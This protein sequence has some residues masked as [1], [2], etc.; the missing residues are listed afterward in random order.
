MSKVTD[1]DHGAKA[2]LKRMNALSAGRDLRV[3][4]LG[5]LAG[6]PKTSAKGE[7]TALTLVE[8]ATIHEFGEGDIPE[9]SFLRAWFDEASPR[10]TGEIKK[11]MEKVAAGKVELTQAIDLL[12]ARYA[13]EIQLRIARGIDPALAEATVTRKLATGMGGETP[14]IA[15]GQLRSAVSWDQKG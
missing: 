5:D 7:A 6:V 10:I 14:L 8:V 3:G 9:R 1:T 4:I 12:G 11:A 2:L 13:G 15:S